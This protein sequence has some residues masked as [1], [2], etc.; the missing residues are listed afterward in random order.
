MFTKFKRFIL[1]GLIVLFSFSINLS[2]VKADTEKVYLG[3][4]TAGFSL[5]SRGAEIIGLSDVLTID[6]VKSPS[7]DAGLLVGD[8]ILSLNDKVVN[9]SLDISNAISNCLEAEIIFERNGIT[10]K[11]IIIPEKDLQN[12]NRL[13][14]FIRDNVK[15][16]GTV[17]FIKDGKFGAL[18][19]PVINENGTFV[20]VTGGEMYNCNITGVIK[21]A[22]GNPGELRGAFEKNEVIGSIVNNK[23][24]GV[25]GKIS[26]NFNYGNLKEVETDC[27]KMGNAKIYSNLSGEFKY[28]DI[29]IIKVDANNKTN[30]NYV[31]KITDSELLELTGGIVQG[32]SGSPIIQN[33]KLIGAVTHVFINDP[34]RGFGILYDNM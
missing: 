6:G 4:F 30:K 24:S 27:G 13:G 17:T 25:Y 1:F 18:G 9:N 33:D 3:G 15:G 34:T 8:V 5:E 26:E 19:H 28:Y 10:H 32:M 23:E 22:R 11:S 20:A 16:I 2:Y 14:V 12:V 31:I 29:S 7:K 21:G